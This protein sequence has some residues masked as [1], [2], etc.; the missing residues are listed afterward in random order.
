MDSKKRVKAR[1]TDMKNVRVWY[2]S[3]NTNGQVADMGRMEEYCAE[4][5]PTWSLSVEGGTHPVMVAP[6]VG[7]G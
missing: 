4:K 7:K 1:K 3:P 5:P 6:F 2:K